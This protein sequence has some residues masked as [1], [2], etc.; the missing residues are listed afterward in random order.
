MT[1]RLRATTKVVRATVRARW[2]S[3]RIAAR[4]RAAARACFYCGVVFEGTG[5][6]Q[7]TVDHRLAKGRGGSNRLTNLV[8]ACRACNQRKGHRTEEDFVAS[9]W[10]A[11]R[12]HDV[13][14][15]Q[16]VL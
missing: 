15:P 4:N 11:R 1:T 8:F 2:R 16:N 5:G 13:A 3:W 10:L 12:R 9:E 7:R 6:R 14:D